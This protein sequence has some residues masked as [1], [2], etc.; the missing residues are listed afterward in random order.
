MDS[1]PT[2]ALVAVQ[3]RATR[4]VTGPGL[5]LFMEPHS[6]SIWLSPEQRRSKRTGIVTARRG[7]PITEAVRLRRRESNLLRLYGITLAA[8]GAMLERQGF[9]CGVCRSPF[10]RNCGDNPQKHGVVIDH[11]HATGRVREVLCSACNLGLGAFRDSPDRLRSAA[12]YVVRH[13]SA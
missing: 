5:G 10:D 9:A 13:A 6:R 11:D 8:F 1:L 12:D 4:V 2:A 3:G 7:Q